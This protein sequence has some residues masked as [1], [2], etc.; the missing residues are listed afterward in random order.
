VFLVVWSAPVGV[1]QLC[2]QMWPNTTT[3]LRHAKPEWIA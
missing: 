2:D 1:V 3:S